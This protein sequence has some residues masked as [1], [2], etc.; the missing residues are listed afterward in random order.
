MKYGYILSQYAVPEWQ[1]YSVD[2]DEFKALIKK[3]VSTNNNKPSTSSSRQEDTIFCALSVQFDR[4]NIFVRSK[5][6]E[7]DRR[8]RNCSK[9]VEEV[10]KQDD[11]R[12]YPISNAQRQKP[13]LRIETEIDSIYQELQALSRFVSSHKLA[14]TKLVKAYN[15][16]SHTQSLSTRYSVLLNNSKS[17]TKRDFT[18]TIVEL[19]FLYDSIRRYF[20][21][22]L[23]FFSQPGSFTNGDLN[24]EAASTMASGSTV[25]WVHNDN[26]VELEVFLL[27]Y[28]SIMPNESFFRRNLIQNTDYKIDSHTRLVYVNSAQA[29][30]N[31]NSQKKTNE[32]VSRVAADLDGDNSEAILCTPNGS[33]LSG[34]RKYIESIVNMSAS[35]TDLQQLDSI[36]KS[37]CS[38]LERKAAAPSIA[39]SVKRTRFEVIGVSGSTVWASLD[40]D[41][42]FEKI[43]TQSCWLEGALTQ[44][45][46]DFPYSVLEI[47]WQGTEPKWLL[48]LK[49]SHTVFEAP[50]FNYFAHAACSLGLSLIQPSWA[51]LLH[52]DIHKI[53]MSK[54]K[55]SRPR[56]RSR[57]STSNTPSFTNASSTSSSTTAEGNSSVETPTDQFQSVTIKGA[58]VNTN[59][60]VVSDVTIRQQRLEAAVKERRASRPK[61]LTVD[62]SSDDERYWNEFDHPEDE[63]GGF[64]VDVSESNTFLHNLPIDRISG[65]SSKVWNKMSKRVHSITELENISASRREADASERESLLGSGDTT[66]AAVSETRD[67]ESAVDESA[68]HAL[69]G[70]HIGDIQSVDRAL[71]M[72]YSVSFAISFILVTILCG[73]IVGGQHASGLLPVY[74]NMLASVGIVFSES[75]A[76]AGLMAYLWRHTVPGF[77]HQVAVF[78]T[79]L[80]IVCAGVGEI[81]MMLL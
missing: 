6:G 54:Q 1:S 78:I 12:T 62:R 44:N 3:C 29:Y 2:Y 76:F 67:L 15:K 51:K 58:V 66:L 20:Q 49:N 22:S 25:F 65:W 23:R 39:V 30:G 33:T 7:L 68:Q 64:F 32:E 13:V 55:P 46:N 56:M 24:F 81:L 8:I 4:I 47:R 5:S 36:G 18:P 69:L 31:I 79:F 42:K 73:I 35:P 80:T 53:P 16:W 61:R 50:G 37:V 71:T 59:S 38:W 60:N 28:L 14:F 77:V 27:K 34:K 48:D 43:T 63:E 74:V 9:A 72:F 40:S 52:E 10:A 19:S 17:F 21:S 41:V 75:I 11:S 57:A 45:N 70:I 26:F